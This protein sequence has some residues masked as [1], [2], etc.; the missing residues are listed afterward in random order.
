MNYVYKDSIDALTKLGLFKN[1][2]LN[3][4]GYY[5]FSKN[6]PLKLKLAVFNTDECLNKIINIG[7]TKDIRFFSLGIGSGCDEILVRGM[8]IKGNGIPE[9]VEN[10][11]QITEKVIL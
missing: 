2:H 11:E 1:N 10:P 5:L 3:N 6:K 9:F 8:S 7:K 4:A